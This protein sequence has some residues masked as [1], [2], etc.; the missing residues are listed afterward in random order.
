M[1]N[2][3]NKPS[4][5]LGDTIAKITNATGIDKV[6]KTVTNS[7]GIEDCGCKA[8]QEALNELFPYQS[9]KPNTFEKMKMVE[10]NGN[11]YVTFE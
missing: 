8:R 6:V 4:K 3:L 9:V 1:N 5:G 10:N 11:N 2:V 7:L